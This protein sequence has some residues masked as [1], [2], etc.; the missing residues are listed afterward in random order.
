MPTV[1]VFEQVLRPDA[2]KPLF[3]KGIVFLILGI[4]CLVFPWAT[5]NLGAYL[6]A[7]L[8]LFVSVAALFSGFAAFG[9]PKSTW[10]MILLG[11]LG[12]VAALFCF[13]NPDFMILIGAVFIGII[14]LISGI[15]DI[16]FAFGRGLSGGQRALMILLGILGIIIGLAFLIFPETGAAAFIYVLGILLI[17]GAVLSFIQGYLYKKEFA[18]LAEE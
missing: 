17:L 16:I 10:W 4:F 6:L 3:L 12:I 13:V 18:E 7:V 1:V 8:L 15:T 14:A 9:E 5:L 2:W 11:I